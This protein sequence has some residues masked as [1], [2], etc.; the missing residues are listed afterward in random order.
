MSKKRLVI[1]GAGGVAREIRWLVREINQQ[2]EAYEFV[3]C[4]VSQ[5][6]ET[7]ETDS[8]EL[9]LG[10]FDWLNAGAADCVAIGIGSPEAR[11][12]VAR[13][14]EDL[15]PGIEFPTLVHPS[16]R[17]D[18]ESWAIERGAILAAG[19]LGTV[20]IEIG[21]FALV[22][23]GCTLGHEARI[24]P[25][26]ALNPGATI[27]GGVRVAQ[28]ALIGSNAVVL[29]YLTVGRGASVGAGAV[30]TRDVAP[31]STVVGV[32]AQAIADRGE[33]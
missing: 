16:V 31:G 3:G 15:V 33:S 17:L 1:A 7:G 25:W 10:G 20:G 30:V 24:G 11:R 9:I 28:E 29:Q 2:R 19:V 26:S 4:V 18:R 27:S 13:E 5:P 14:I 6:E 22:G 21:E 32:P 8:P 12:R 23:V